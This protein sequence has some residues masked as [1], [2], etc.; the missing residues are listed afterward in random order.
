M[1][2]RIRYTAVGSRRRVWIEQLRLGIALTVTG[3]VLLALET[4]VLGRIPLPF[5]HR[6]APALSL[7]FTLGVGYLHGERE[8]GVAGLLTGWLADATDGGG[9]LLLPLAYFLCG[10]LCGLVGKRRLAHNLPSFAVFSLGGG[11]AL[12]GFTLL[13]AAF[14][15]RGIPPVLPILWGF[16]PVLILTVLFSPAVYGLLW[17]ERRLLVRG[18]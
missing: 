9:L 1:T 6:G 7:L 16:L 14:T 18:G 8:G 13:D 17:V 2:G 10:F 4:T 15:V 3:L 12:G 11:M 5:L